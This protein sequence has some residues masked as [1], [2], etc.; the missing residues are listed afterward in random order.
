V[1]EYPP[2]GQSEGGSLYWDVLRSILTLIVILFLIFI[3]IY[4]G[5]VGSRNQTKN[6]WAQIDVQLKRRADLIP[7]LMETVKGYRDNL[8]KRTRSPSGHE[9]RNL[10]QLMAMLKEATKIAPNP[11]QN[12]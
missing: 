3:G 8:G 1:S 7:N 11:Y 5:L 4:N 9:I 10:N 12:S 2:R 6:A